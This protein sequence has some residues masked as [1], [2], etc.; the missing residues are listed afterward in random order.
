MKRIFIPILA[1]TLLIACTR[2]PVYRDDLSAGT[3]AS[4]IAKSLP[5]SA[6]L[7]RYTE[8]DI[9]FY[10]EIP[11]ELSEDRCVMMQQSSVAIDEIGVFHAVDEESAVRI[12]EL[13]EEYIDRSEETKGDWLLN[14]LPE[15]L[16]KLEDAE[17]LHRGRYVIYLILSKA[18]RRIA[19]ENIEKILS[20]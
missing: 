16:R 8:E 7:I 18:D 2:T 9:E 13:L 4:E 12:E 6:G 3:V 20:E 17:I 19:V 10:L 14:T 15:E 5:D 11:A 1:L